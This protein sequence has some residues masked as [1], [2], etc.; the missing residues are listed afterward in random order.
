[1]K[2]VMTKEHMEQP[3]VGIREKYV[4]WLEENKAAGKVNAEEE[5]EYQEH[6]TLLDVGWMFIPIAQPA[7]SR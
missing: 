6:I 3:L 2:A 1:M 4:V 5:A 7:D